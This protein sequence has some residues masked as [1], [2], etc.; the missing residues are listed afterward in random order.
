MNLHGINNEDGLG[1]L[2][3]WLTWK[4]PDH[5]FFREEDE[6]YFQGPSKNP[7]SELGEYL[8]WTDRMTDDITNGRWAP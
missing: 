1:Q 2:M 5:D 8:W 3:R 6:I 7:Y 4:Y